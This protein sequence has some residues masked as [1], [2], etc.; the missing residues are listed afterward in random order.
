MAGWG[1]V[2][3]SKSRASHVDGLAKQR[4]RVHCSL[5]T[6]AHEDNENNHVKAV[7]RWRW[8]YPRSQIHRN[9]A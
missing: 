2:L 7:I 1:V 4:R 3:V 9:T 5:V 6:I 8:N